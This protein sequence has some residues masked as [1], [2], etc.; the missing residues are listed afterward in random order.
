[1][2][3]LFSQ[4]AEA[5]QQAALV[6]ALEAVLG[7]L[8][9]WAA[10]PRP[11]RILV[12][13]VF[14]AGAATATND[15]RRELQNGG[16]IPRI[17]L[18][19]PEV[20]GDALGG[21]TSAAPS[22]GERIYLD[23]VWLRGATSAEVEAVLLEEIG[24]ALDQRLNPGRDRTGDEGE[25]F[26]ALI[27]GVTP[28]PAAA[29]ENDH[30]W[31]SLGGTPVAIEAAVVASVHLSTIAAGTGGFVINGQA[32]GDLSGERL[33]GAGDVNGDGLADLLIGVPQGD[34]AA[35]TNAGR[36]YVVFGATT[37]RPVNL[38]AVAA[39]SDGFVIN[40]QAAGEASGISVAGAGDLNGDGLADLLLGTSTHRSYVV[41]GKTTSAPTQLSAIARGVGGFVING[42]T[43]GEGSGLSVAAGGD[44][45]GDGLADL[46]LGAPGADPAAGADAGRSYVLFGTT[47]TTAVNLSAVAAGTGGF[48][49]D[50]QDVAEASGSRVSSVGDVN[51]DGLADLLV[52][53]PN[54]DPAAG[55]D[56][57]RAYVIFGRTSGTP[58]QL[59]AIARGLGG[60]VINGQRAGDRSGANA[61]G[62]G[63]VNGD[64]LADLLVNS[65]DGTHVVFGRAATTAVDLST[66]AAGSG[67]FV[68]QGDGSPP[69]EESTCRIAGAGDVNG[70]GLA[71]LLIGVNTS[72]AIGGEGAGRTFLVFGQS[73]TSAIAL[74]AVA[75]GR[76]GFLIHGQSAEDFSGVAV[77]G[78]GDVNGDGLADLL[79]GASGGDPAGLSRAGRSYVLFG[80]TTG[81]FSAS[82]VDWVGTTGN[83]S[84][85]GSTAGETFVGHTGNDTLTGNGGADVLIG[86]SGNDRFVLNASNLTALSQPLGAGGNNQQLARVDGGSGFDTLALDGAALSLNLGSVTNPSASDDTG[87]S[88]LRAIEAIDLTGTGN[89][90][91]SLDPSDIQAL[92]GFNWLNRSTASRLGFTKGSLTPA[93]LVQRHQLVI[94]GNAGD[95]L[96]VRASAGTTWT[97]GGTLQGSGSFAGRFHVWNSSSGEAQLLVHTAIAHSFD[98]H[99]T[100][101]PDNLRGTPVTDAI[102]GGAGN[103]TLT[104]GPGLDTLSGGDGNDTFAFLTVPAAAD[105]DR[106]TDFVSGVD[107]LALSRAAY[108]AFKRQTT[109]TPD[110]FAA[111]PGLTTATTASQRFLYDLSSGL[112]RYDPDG[113]GRSAAVEVAQLGDLIPP[114]LRATDILF[115]A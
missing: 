76:G 54:A 98:V 74:S 113:T 69:P 92:A 51:G 28:D 106:I 7:R 111:A 73:G 66:I 2:L 36:S 12:R 10:D 13:Q 20:L 89:N 11:F 83:D 67:G 88:R 26:S 31:I 112:L 57:G 35:G 85:T 23:R 71:D 39:G 82:T 29:K 14:G 77:D 47:S 103:D 96:T 61:V 9:D 48:V 40:G 56:A 1:M 49:I 18:L 45:N 108:R 86:G 115:T 43:A 21:Y 32:A 33:V 99:G 50:G 81:A 58:I 19:D 95:T 78:A 42:A 84:Q 94:H 107:T 3:H 79:V 30:R 75:A 102:R 34:P 38:S 6:Q 44:V 4:P 37:T 87:T 114:L 109:L 15:L 100:S 8:S 60:F 17:E 63:D 68:I 70:D 101:G 59:S 5:G 110:Q 24:H 104:G 91:L 52:G 64:G 16:V 53:A 22:G 55:A 90:A 93:A 65:G 105:R 80:S 62:V 72:R 25:R 41:F 97:N 46:I 27:R